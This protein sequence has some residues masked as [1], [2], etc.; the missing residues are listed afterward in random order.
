MLIKEKE[1]RQRRLS[2]SFHIEYTVD[3]QSFL[4]TCDL[5]SFRKEE[6]HMSEILRLLY[7]RF[8]PLPLAEDEQEVEP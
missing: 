6:R 5:V 7:D 3:K 8:P 1:S 2:F 4:T